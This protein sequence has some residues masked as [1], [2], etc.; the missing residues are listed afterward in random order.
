M[1]YTIRHLGPDDTALMEGI[2]SMF[3]IAFDDVERYTANRPTASY[4]RQLLGSPSF[5][6][7]AAVDAGAVVGGLVAYELKKF[8]QETSEIY[9]YDLAVLASHRRQGMATALIEELKVIG[10]RLGATVIF[11]QADTDEDD[12]PAIALYT[13]L[14]TRE[15]VLHFDI[16]IPEADGGSEPPVG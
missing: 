7:L 15:D 2:S 1:S 4:L 10:A 11:V 9:I 3:G 8:E 5:I 16:A 13:T 14:G 12:L 6:A